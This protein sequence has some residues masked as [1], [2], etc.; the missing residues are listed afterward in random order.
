[1][2]YASIRLQNILDSD[3]AVEQFEHSSTQHIP[4]QPDEDISDA[5]IS[6]F[7]SRYD[8]NEISQYRHRYLVDK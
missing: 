5:S 8:I 3:F 6:L 7:R 1:M 2:F 4:G